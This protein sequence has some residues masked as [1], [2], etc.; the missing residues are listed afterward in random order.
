MA[1]GGKIKVEAVQVSLWRCR[2]SLS[3][4]MKAVRLRLNK[5]D[6]FE[7]YGFRYVFSLKT[8]KYIVILQLLRRNSL[9]LRSNHIKKKRWKI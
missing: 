3:D 8:L 7:K 1:L 9:Y 6:Y 2:A 4:L 5:M